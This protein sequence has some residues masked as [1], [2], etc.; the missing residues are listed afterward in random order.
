MT[1]IHSYL[2]PD[3]HASSHVF[4]PT[5]I[6]QLPCSNSKRYPNTVDFILIPVYV[7]MLHQGR[8]IK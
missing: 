1:F 4:P 6:Q 7:Q 8:V 2:M 3:L 5:T